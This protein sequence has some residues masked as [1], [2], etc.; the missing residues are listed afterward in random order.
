MK[1]PIKITLIIVVSILLYIG[2]YYLLTSSSNVKNSWSLPTAIFDSIIFSLFGILVGFLLIWYFQR[3]NLETSHRSQL[4]IAAGL[5][6]MG[7]FGWLSICGFILGEVIAEKPINTKIKSPRKNLWADLEGLGFKYWTY[8]VLIALSSLIIPIIMMV[9]SPSNLSTSQYPLILLAISVLTLCGSFFK[10][11]KSKKLGTS[12]T[13]FQRSILII[14]G[15]L[16]LIEILL[17]IFTFV[18]FNSSPVSI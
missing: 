14:I 2:F 7:L 4:E 3:K 18:N 10:E 6:W 8:S 9:I 11:N 16:F 13:Q 17:G 15:G 5:I 1:K 12:H